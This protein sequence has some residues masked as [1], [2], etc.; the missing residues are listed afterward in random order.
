VVRKE[1]KM[2]NIFNIPNV[3]NCS[4][5]VK[6]YSKSHSFM[7]ISVF[8]L[9]YSE[10]EPLHYIH[11]NG[12]IYFEGPMSWLGANFNETFTDRKLEILRALPGFD[13]IPDEALQTHFHLI[14]TTS[15]LYQ[16]VT[17]LVQWYYLSEIKSWRFP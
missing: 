2:D 8:S 1:N 17:I 4:C 9:E 14:H 7:E 12:V 5:Y 15:K 3:E 6:G 16:P 11:L 10:V 13:P